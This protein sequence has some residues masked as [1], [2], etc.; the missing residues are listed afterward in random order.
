MSFQ[1]VLIVHLC[2]F[3]I[4]IISSSRLFYLCFHTKTG[5][6]THNTTLLYISI[7]YI[8][9]C[10]FS[11]I[12]ISSSRF[13]DQCFH[14]TEGLQTHTTALPDFPSPR[15]SRCNAVEGREAQLCKKIAQ[16]SRRLPKRRKNY[17]IP[18]L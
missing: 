14:T 9:L 11:I 17:C 15:G 1:Y 18:S 2:L 13:S 10:V 12:I 16:K 7:N 3:S 4:F 6:K 5:L 8:H